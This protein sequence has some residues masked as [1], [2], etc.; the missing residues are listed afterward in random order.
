M[1]WKDLGN[2]YPL[3]EPVPYPPLEWPEGDELVFGEGVA[4]TDGRETVSTSFASLVGSRRTRYGFSALSHQTLGA[5]FTLTN[6]VSLRG[7]DQLGFA[8]SQRPAPSAGAIHPIHVITHLPCSP[9]LHRYDPFAHSLRELHC[10]ADVAK[11]RE[12]MNVV[13]NGGDGVL[14]MFV[15]EPGRTFAKYAQASSLVWRDAGI[16][17]GYFSMAAEALGLNFSPLGVTGEPWAGQL[18]QK[19]GL[20]GVGAAFV[21]GRP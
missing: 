16:L 3:P 10:D 15:A 8:L 1:T 6:R 2:P 17:Q 5:L 12:A 11:L 19:T 9:C 7:S 4:T 21:G 20:A 14:L 13:V 18:V